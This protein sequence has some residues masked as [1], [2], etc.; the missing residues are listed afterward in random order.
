MQLETE[1]LILRQFKRTDWKAVHEYA[2]DP[3]VSKFMEWGPNSV[4]D[5]M[6]FIDMSLQG[7]KEK[8]RRNFDFAVTLKDGGTLIGACGLRLLPWDSK[9]ADVGYCYNRNYWRKGYASEA[10]RSLLRMGFEEF[11]LH[12][13]FATCDADNVGSAAVMKANG[14]RQ[15]AHFIEDKFIKGHWRNTL[16]YAILSSEWGA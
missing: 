13:I 6:K 10:C 4:D 9:Q 8:P 1:R 2:A 12:R 16:L 14:M 3:E 11:K 15:E 5:T 7:Q